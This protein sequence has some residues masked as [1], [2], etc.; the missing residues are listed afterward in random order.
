MPSDG[1]GDGIDVLSKPR[2]AASPGARRSPAH[3]PLSAPGRPL[4]HQRPLRRDR[5]P[6][7]SERRSTLKAESP[8]S[9]GKVVEIECAPPGMRRCERACADIK[10]TAEILDTVENGC[11]PHLIMRI[12]QADREWGKKESTPGPG[13]GGPLRRPGLGGI[14][15]DASPTTPRCHRADPNPGRRW[16]RSCRPRRIDV[17]ARRCWGTGVQLRQERLRRQLASWRRH[18]PA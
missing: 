1:D 6:P 5:A 18:T 17:A 13:P 9:K 15:L 12:K 10:A 4:Q 2:P 14:I 8:G 16:R 11:A 3:R 7:R